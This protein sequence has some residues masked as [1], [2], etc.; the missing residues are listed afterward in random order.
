MFEKVSQMAEHVATRA[1]RRDF[2]GRLGRSAMIVAGVVAGF[3]TRPCAAAR[4]PS[5]CPEGTRLVACSGNGGRGCKG[6]MCCPDGT[7][8]KCLP[9]CNCYCT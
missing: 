6:K 3:G 5:V 4:K 1:S 7:S 8:C 2:L 9:F